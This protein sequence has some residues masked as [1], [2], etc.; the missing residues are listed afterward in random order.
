MRA[1]YGF[2]ESDAAARRLAARLAVPCR[3][4]SIHRFPD[5]ESLVRVDPP[6]ASAVLYRSLDRPNDKLIEILLAASALRDGGCR[7]I[8]LVAPYLAYMRQ[9]VAFHPGEPVSQKVVGKLIAGAFDRVITVN[10][11][12]HRTAEIQSVFPGIPAAA[13][14]AAPAM[15]ALLAVEGVPSDTVV[16]G[17]DEESRPWA[18]ALAAPLGL[19][20]I[21]AR[22]LRSGDRDVAVTFPDAAAVAGRPVLLL[23]DMASTGETLAACA[24]AS[25][26]AGAL[27]VE[28]FVV[29]ALFDEAA[30]RKLASAGI[31]R[32]RSSDSIPH[33]SNA[34]ELADLLAAAL[35]G[36]QGKA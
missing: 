15:A 29:H 33:S 17:P 34:L 32:L 6:A 28:A 20:V 25:R 12:L 13:I 14:D 23:D 36:R 11:H 7:E 26:A 3:P 16:V 19:A 10:P 9:D 31:G 27:R 30:M 35:G 5:G 21:T 4:V 22:K 2:P 8:T 24:R 18:E 1:V